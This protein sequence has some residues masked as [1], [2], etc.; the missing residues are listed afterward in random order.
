M[1]TSVERES[2]GNCVFGLRIAAETRFVMACVCVTNV[3]HTHTHTHKTV[4]RLLAS[5]A[6]TLV[7]CFIQGICVKKKKIKKRLMWKM[8]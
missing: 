5:V 7:R 3:T 4:P 8:D 6:D 2:G 1:C